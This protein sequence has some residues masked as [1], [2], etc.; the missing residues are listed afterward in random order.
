[1]TA[2]SSDPT[3]KHLLHENLENTGDGGEEG[4]KI[5][6]KALSDLVVIGFVCVCVCV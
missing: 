4:W 3:A 5:P 1:M 2:F 6:D